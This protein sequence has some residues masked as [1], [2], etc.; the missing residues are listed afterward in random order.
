MS[1]YGRFTSDCFAIRRDVALGAGGWDSNFIGWGEE[2]V[3]FAD[4]CQMSGAALHTPQHPD[5]FAC[6][7]DHP[8]D[9]PL[10]KCS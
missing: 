6:H 1:S 9:H 8:I 3:E 10:C 4:R 2:D 7:V 5:F